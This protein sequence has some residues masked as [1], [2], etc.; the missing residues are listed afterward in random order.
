MHRR[1][2][3][4]SGSI[5]SL[6][7][8][9]NGL[10]V[11]VLSQTAFD[12]ILDPENEKILVLIQQNGGNDGLNTVIPIDMYSQLSQARSNIL[13]PEN[14][15]LQIEDTVGLHPAM[16][17]IKSLYDE[18]LMTIIQNV[19]YP[20]QNRS[21]FRS[22]DI[23]DTGSAA[24]EVLATGWIGRYLDSIHPGY[25]EGYPSE[26]NPHPIAITLG[27][28]VSE[29][30][31][32]I[33]SNFSLAIND[34]T[35]LSKIPGGDEG[36][37]PDLPYGWELEYLRQ[38]IAQ[39]NQYSDILEEVANQGSTASPLWPDAGNNS[40]ADQLKTVV[41]LI[42][43]GLN[44]RIYMVNINGFDTHANQTVAGDPT[45]GFHASLL[46]QTSEA[47]SAFMDDLGRQGL[48][49]RVLTATRSEF[50]R[51]IVSNGSYGTDHGDAAPLL[52]FGSCLQAGIIG[53]NPDIPFN[54]DP[55][56]GVSMKYDFR[57]I[58][59]SILLDWLGASQ[60][61]IND[62]FS[63]DFEQIPFINPCQTTASPNFQTQA[64]VVK[65]RTYPN[66][67]YDHLKV[68]FMAPGGYTRQSLFNQ[69][70]QEVL[71]LG[72]ETLPMGLQSRSFNIPEIPPGTYTY[73]LKTK[74]KKETRMLLHF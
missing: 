23:W 66:P 28:T 14:Q 13:I 53:D 25:P 63:N 19:G 67:F 33:A 38:I 57:N 56:L 52:I 54:A 17:E 65:L 64:N 68:E 3:L 10:K 35:S 27:P 69:H 61:T 49:N 31:Q 60:S 1:S 72:V 22:S 59:G 50:G 70:G 39:T 43:G 20:N 12:Q 73:Q 45:R 11:G 47:I 7:I 34:P 55:G 46:Q 40:L 62:I 5:L 58:F 71:V 9:L 29:T 51:K 32:G 42:S 36:L 44:T 18:G 37:L 48:Q 21:H 6:P 8:M 24:S 15:V 4:R 16:T 26:E 41:Q 30:C 2:F 74:N